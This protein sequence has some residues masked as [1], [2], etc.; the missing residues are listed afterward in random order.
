MFFYR[1]KWPSPISHLLF[2]KGLF[3]ESQ[4]VYAD[5]PHSLYHF[6]ENLSYDIFYVNFWIKNVR[7][8]L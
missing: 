5:L 4:I 6:I 3:Y 8:N 1:K 2:E 7:M